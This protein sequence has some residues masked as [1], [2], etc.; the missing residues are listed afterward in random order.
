MKNKII[1]LLLVFL[2]V[3]LTEY[4][5]SIMFKQYIALYIILHI[6]M[7]IHIILGIGLSLDLSKP[8]EKYDLIIWELVHALLIAGSFISINFQYL[9]LSI[10]FLSLSSILTSIVFTCEWIDIG[11]FYKTIFKRIKYNYKYKLYKHSWSFDE[12]LKFK[13]E[14]DSLNANKLFFNKY[15]LCLTKNRNMYLIHRISD[16]TYIKYSL[17]L[18]WVVANLNLIIQL[19]DEYLLANK[20]QNF[21]NYFKCSY[22][23][24]DGQIQ[25]RFDNNIINVLDNLSK[26][27]LYELLNICESTK[28]YVN[29]RKNIITID[30]YDSYH[31]I[32]NLVKNTIK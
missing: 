25:F 22:S 21:F 12:L 2:L 15:D 32:I 8:K 10:V 1:N 31:N 7:I 29:Y 18:S 14:F 3:S 17:S 9:T 11:K 20:L 30:K 16:K 27:D 24:N 6:S 28:L 19:N 26:A 4:Y 5:N 13:S 23:D